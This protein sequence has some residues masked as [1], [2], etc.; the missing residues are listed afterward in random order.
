MSVNSQWTGLVVSLARLHAYSSAIEWHCGWLLTTAGWLWCG[1]VSIR[2]TG[3]LQDCTQSVTPV[4]DV[5]G[6]TGVLVPSRQLYAAVSKVTQ[7]W[8]CD[9]YMGN[10]R[11]RTTYHFMCT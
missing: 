8:A 2:L 6:D 1:P 5:Y 10:C 7:R 11:L 4:T 3:S 9:N